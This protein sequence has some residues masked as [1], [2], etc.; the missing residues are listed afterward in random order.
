MV[1][2][3]NTLRLF[4]M[5][6]ARR[7]KMTGQEWMVKRPAGETIRDT[8][9]VSDERVKFLVDCIES[10]KDLPT[11]LLTLEREKARNQYPNATVGESARFSIEDNIYTSVKELMYIADGLLSG[12][13]SRVEAA[14]GFARM[15]WN[16]EFLSRDV[17]IAYQEAMAFMTIDGGPY[18]NA[19]KR[20]RERIALMLATSVIEY[21]A[22]ASVAG[23]TRSGYEVSR[24]ESQ[25]TLFIDTLMDYGIA[26]SALRSCINGFEEGKRGV[27]DI[28]R[29]KM[30]A[31]LLPE[32]R[33]QP[34]IWDSRNLLLGS[35]SNKEVVEILDVL[36][37]RI[38][39]RADLAQQNYEALYELPP[40]TALGIIAAGHPSSIGKVLERGAREDI[41][42]MGIS[43]EEG[44]LQHMAN[45]MLEG[46]ISCAKY[47]IL[48]P[49]GTQGSVWKK[50]PLFVVMEKNIDSQY[51]KRGEYSLRFEISEDHHLYYLVPSQEHAEI[52]AH[53]IK[54]GIKAGLM[55]FGQGV[56][57][58]SK[59][60]TYDEFVSAE[61]D[62]FS[63]YSGFH[64]SRRMDAINALAKVWE[65]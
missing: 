19:D 3:R 22:A 47:G 39:Q 23:K 20:G 21:A 36:I 51:D 26:E 38:R 62:A 33:A 8:I 64:F 2:D 1:S 57:S 58:L 60:V 6:P 25:R 55:T 10:R 12:E 41:L 42:A 29:A 16:D 34:I 50:G 40:G 7:V 9:R 37:T 18:S 17:R 46:S 30:F 59:T 15:K 27:Y 13:P 44:G 54:E 32:D 65:K 56:T 49:E 63:K 35:M 31:D 4:G 45:I 53:T 11:P 5:D 48:A 43:D 14:E 61:P 28:G 24:I 52:L